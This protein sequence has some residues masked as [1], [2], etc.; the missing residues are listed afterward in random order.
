[1]SPDLAGPDLSDPQTLNQYRYGLNNPLRYIDPDG[2]YE[3][4]VH[5]D[6]TKVL[7]YAAGYAWSGVAE[8]PTVIKTW[9]ITL[10]LILSIWT[11]QE[12]V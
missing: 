4:D 12:L 11:P 8:L 3:A 2:M 9:M 7:A 5:Y 6:L 1:M 10:Q